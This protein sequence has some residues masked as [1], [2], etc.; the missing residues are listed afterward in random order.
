MNL[1]CGVRIGAGLLWILPFVV[2]TAPAASQTSQL[3]RVPTHQLLMPLPGVAV[4]RDSATWKRLWLRYEER[5]YGDSGVVH[6][7]VPAIDF[8]TEM[9]VAVS[10]GRSS[11]CSN[12]AHYIGQ[13]VERPDSLV[14]VI[15]SAG[16]GE[17][18]LTCDMII[19]P[20][21][22]VRLGRSAKPVAFH[23]YEPGIPTP[24]EAT[25]W[26]QPSSA[27]LDR[28]D[29]AERRVLTAAL[30]R[31]P[32]TPLSTLVTIVGRLSVNDGEIANDLLRRPDV[33]ASTELLIALARLDKHGGSDAEDV[34]VVRHGL[35]LAG[36]PATP[37]DVLGMLIEHLRGPWTPHHQEVARLLAQN[38]TVWG[39]EALLRQ[40]IFL[41]QN[42]RDVSGEACKVYVARWISRENPAPTMKYL[43]SQILLPEPP[44]VDGVRLH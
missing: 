2:C 44:S 41:T 33:L 12:S 1:T 32:A 42:R 24:S 19:E 28:M 36:D 26:N 34:L 37:D 7:E 23:S 6:A 31:D 17:P 10:L 29:Q 4:I 3:R 9:L 39:T 8:R 38:P 5:A 27:E 22:V 11:G 18:Q 43:C 35:A 30:V 40:F 13:V 15:G 25:W 16:E 21:D 20:I 14:V